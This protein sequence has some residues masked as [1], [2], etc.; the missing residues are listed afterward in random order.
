[1]ILVTGGMGFIGLHTTRELLDAGSGVVL[2][3]YQV[4][5]EPDFLAGDLGTR[6]AVET[7]DTGNSHAVHDLMSRHEID[8]VIHLAV[9]ALNRLAPAQEA[10]ANLTGLLNVLEAARVHGARRVTIAS[11]VAVYDGAGESPWREDMPLPVASASPT[12]AFKKMTETVA[13]HYADRTGMDV[14]MLRIG[15]IYGPLYHSMMNLPS[16]LAHAAVRGSEPDLSGP[17]GVP[18]AGDGHDLCYVRDC[19]RA[20]RLVHLAPQLAHRIYN[21]G[22]GRLTTYG[23]LAGAVAAARPGPP[24]RLRP[25]TSPNG[26]GLYSGGYMDVS[27]IR[28]ETGYEPA[29]DVKTAIADYCAWLDTHDQ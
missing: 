3:R 19:A 7:V 14:L 28:A 20:I 8:S 21:I 15:M 29:Y 22:G 4:R 1:M 10:Q 2:T 9:P 26:G 13:D 27:R 18:H 23:E 24:V 5:R 16:R 6:V 11:S 12:G 25:G 17:A